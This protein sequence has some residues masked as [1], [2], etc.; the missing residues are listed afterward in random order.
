MQSRNQIVEPVAFVIKARAALASDLGQYGEARQHLQI[1]LE[2]SREVHNPGGTGLVL[3]VL[4]WVTYLEGDFHEAR[5]LS[6]ESLRLSHEVGERWMISNNLSNLGKI[7]CKLN[8]FDAAAT[9]LREAL[10]IATEIGA[11]PLT[12][13]ILVSVAAVYKE[14]GRYQQAAEL[15]SLAH[16]HPS[17]YNEVKQQSDILLPE[18]RAVLSP[19]ALNAAL[20]RGAQHDLV[21]TVQKIINREF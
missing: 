20:E 1:S 12:L 4:A 19:V 3:T 7:M 16:N 13:E 8:D 18:L 2:I 9:Y 15:L 10:E 17:T 11:V 5:V 21:A 6:L 14:L